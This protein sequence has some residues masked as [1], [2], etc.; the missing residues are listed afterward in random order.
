V[1]QR[2]GLRSL[3]VLSVRFIEYN[4]ELRVPPDCSPPNT[5]S[6][7]SW[8]IRLP[9]DINGFLRVIESIVHWPFSNFSMSLT[10]VLTEPVVTTPPII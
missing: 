8:F 10:T 9:Q 2:R 5:S 7:F 3:V 4:V 6:S 1:N